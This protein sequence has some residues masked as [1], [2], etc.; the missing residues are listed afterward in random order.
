MLTKSIFPQHPVLA[1]TA[2]ALLFGFCVF[3]CE[4][5]AVTPRADAPD[6]GASSA[7]AGQTDATPSDAATTTA[8]GSSR[9]TLTTDA[10]PTTTWTE[11]PGASA[12][13]GR[14]LDAGVVL[15]AIGS[16]S[17]GS[18]SN[19][20]ALDAGVD[21]AAVDTAPDEPF[22]P[23]DA[24]CGL[25]LT[26]NR[27]SRA[28]PTVGIVEWSVAGAAPSSAKVVYALT[29]P[30]A[31]TLNLGGEAP[32]SLD[33][34]NLRTLLLGLKPLRNYTFHVEVT[35]GA[36]VCTGA[37][38]ALP[39]TGAFTELPKLTVDVTLPE[40]RE[41]G[42][43]VTSTGA[44][45][46]S[47]AFIIDADGEIVWSY[48]GPSSV[49]RAHMDYEGERMWM[50]KLNVSNEGG[51]MRS[52][53]MDGSDE[54]QNV[55]GLENAHHDFTVMP[56]GKVAA[57][58]WSVAGIDPESDLVV[59]APDGT[60]TTPFRIGANLYVSAG[61]H[62]NAVHYIPADGSFTISDRNPNALV[63][64][65]GS[66]ELQWQL[67]GS[68]EGAPAGAR[69]SAQTW[70]VNHGHHLLEDGTFVLFN[71]AYGD[72]SHVLEFALNDTE[73][74]FTADLVEDYSGTAHSSNL[75]DVQRL[76]GGNTLV[77]YS[78]DGKLVELDP[79]WNV[80][81]TFSAR[82]G[83]ASWRSSLYGAP[84]RP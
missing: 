68:C 67:G 80:V 62:A 77:T 16:V 15:D 10:G 8:S 18:V 32:V 11:K 42:F 61:Y 26:Q 41:S 65:S 21:A 30:T 49:S 3:G 59:R 7:D 52:V 78:V 35:R 13:S 45:T 27:L 63:K 69:C 9:E 43:I 82:V 4:S 46:P 55:P 60:W 66:G 19:D 31:S 38:F 48:P 56:G 5:D 17:D 36:E 24:G 28:I 20:G 57:L 29:D 54:Q 79:A 33:K 83:Y 14:R 6:S 53:A 76:P 37:E 72:V 2:T 71:N 44:S 50:Q 51:E 64:V 23:L 73:A 1:T 84:E 22:A 40:S 39:T 58:V 70:E 75:G 81:Q 47:A 12:D 74:S 34:A 25:T